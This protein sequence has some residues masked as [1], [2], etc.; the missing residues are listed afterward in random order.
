MCKMKGWLRQRLTPTKQTY[1]KPMSLWL[2]THNTL[3][4]IKDPNQALT[5]D[6]AFKHT[7]KLSTPNRRS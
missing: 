2:S 5:Q 6:Q 1:T 7:T 3:H 4:S